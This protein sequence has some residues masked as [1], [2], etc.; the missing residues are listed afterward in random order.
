MSLEN[1]NDDNYEILLIDNNS[2]LDPV[3]NI[4]IELFL[5]KTQVIFV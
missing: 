3:K 1:L 2:K 4:L 5:K